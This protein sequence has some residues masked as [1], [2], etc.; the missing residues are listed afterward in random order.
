MIDPEAVAKKW[1]QRKNK[2]SMNYDNMSRALRYYYDKLILTKVAGKRHTYR[3]NFHA[4]IQSMQATSTPSINAEQL[5]TSLLQLNAASSAVSY[6]QASAYQSS[7]AYSCTVAKPTYTLCY[8]PQTQTSRD[9]PNQYLT[10]QNSSYSTSC[11][12][13][14]VQ[15]NITSSQNDSKYFP[16]FQYGQNTRSTSP[17]VTEP[18]NYNALPNNYNDKYV[19]NGL[20]SIPCRQQ[21]NGACY[22]TQHQ[23]YQRYTPY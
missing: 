7:P 18:M 20:P 1:G 5:Q 9:L 8:K 2:V 10:N 3:F 4:I 16:S 19:P 13:G 14:N 22:R 6:V 15:N 17:Y 23:S 11:R 21:E 12:Y